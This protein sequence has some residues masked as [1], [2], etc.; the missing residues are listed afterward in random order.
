M[1]ELLR[2][3]NYGWGWRRQVTLYS[4]GEGNNV[5]KRWRSDITGFDKDG[6][7]CVIDVTILTLAAA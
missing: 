7:M 1:L 3:S 6:N 2:K 4:L 5:S